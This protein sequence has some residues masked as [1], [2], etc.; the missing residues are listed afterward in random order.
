MEYGYIRVSTLDQN[1]DRQ[2]RAMAARGIPRER[3]FPDKQ[4]G[5]DFHRPA[6]ARPLRRLRPGHLVYVLSSDCL[7]RHSEEVHNHWRSIA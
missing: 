7:E 4:S 1:E 6:Y 3:M 2:R 5:K